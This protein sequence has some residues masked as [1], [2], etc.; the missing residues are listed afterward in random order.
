MTLLNTALTIA[1]LVASTGAIAQS[2]SETQQQFPA[3]RTQSGLCS[4]IQW[5]EAMLDRHPALIAACREVVVADG[6]KWARFEAK[7]VGVDPD[8]TVQFSVRDR[9]DRGIEQ[10]TLRPAPGQVAYMNDRPV[11]FTRLRASDAISLYMP[12]NQYGFVTAPK[13]APLATVVADDVA[14]SI[15]PTAAPTAIAA[16]AEPLPARLPQTASPIAWMGLSA[17]LMLLAGCGL[18]LRRVVGARSNFRS[19]G[20]DIS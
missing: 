5:N 8:G 16:A 1:M 15:T 19:I 9:R 13:A 20:V 3:T 17:M 14:P 11:E 18:A 10:V 12:E 6:Q 2:Q 4:D 7:F